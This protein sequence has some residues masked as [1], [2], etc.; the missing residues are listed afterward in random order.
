MYEVLREARTA[1]R[2]DWESAG[3]TCH[4]HM[5]HVSPKAPS[6][7]SLADFH[8]KEG[9]TLLDFHVNVS[10]ALPDFLSKQGPTMPDS[11]AW[12]SGNAE[13]SI[14]DPGHRGGQV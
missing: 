3:L 14:A 13:L 7:K 1:Q 8:C 2:K 11:L 6:C 4:S 5:P 9:P 12:K 10:L